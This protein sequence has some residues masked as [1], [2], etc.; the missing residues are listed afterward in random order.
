MS[1]EELKKNDYMASSIKVLEGLEAVRKRPAMYIGSTDSRGLNHLAL[2][3]IDNSIDEAMASYCDHV[4]VRLIEPDVLSIEDNGRGIPV[5]IHPQLGISGV[6]VALTKLHAGGKFDAKSYK[7]SGGL[8][9]VGISVVNALSEWLVAEVRRDGKLYQQ[10]YA[11]GIPQGPL[12]II[13]DAEQNGTT[14]KFKP[15]ADIFE[16]T[17]FDLPFL[18]N[19]LKE[20]AFLNKNLRIEFIDQTTDTTT[21]FHYEGGIQEYILHINEGKN[22]VPEQPVYVIRQDE[23]FFAEI[24]FCYNNTF[25]ETVYSYVNS[26]HTR[27]GGTHLYGFRAALLQVINEKANLL[28]YNKDVTKKELFN[29]D[30]VKEGLS[31]I[32]NVRLHD[33][34]FEGQTKGRLGNSFVKKRTEEI[35]VQEFSF[36]LDKNPEIA[37]KIIERCLVAKDAREAAAKARDLIRR[38]SFLSN[39]VLP[40]KLADCS[41]KDPEKSELFIVEGDSAGGSAKQGRDRKTQAILPLR[42]KILNVEKANLEKILGNEEIK[43][44]IAALGTGI[45]KE[46]DPKKLRYHKIFI[47]TDADVDGSHIRTLLLTLFYRYMFPLIE[48]GFVYIAQ[49]PLYLITHNRKE[50]YVY[51]DRELQDTLKN[52]SGKYELQRYKGLG[53]MSA[54]QLS[55]TTM[56]PEYRVILKV[57]ADDLLA[58]EE[59]FTIL[60]GEKVQ[61]RKEFIQKHAHEVT[62]I[63]I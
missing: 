46:F 59:I 39:S 34:Q 17:S 7:V 26:I 53:E 1:N 29:S 60:M 23:D 58:S 52:I 38:K 61:P 37:K 47:M 42:G 63:D 13:G 19:R 55:R 2:E 24:A 62:N 22:I 11:R 25:G 20:L 9:G 33:P 49:P 6:E 8:H 3:V 31:A 35:V 4:R 40:G 45:D 51:N 12:E 16:T 54:E 36:L 43:A 10:T 15:D 44:L 18:M 14:I 30:D 56:N 28:K 57:N 5:D 41:E 27:D 48:G 50:T 21:H 32:V